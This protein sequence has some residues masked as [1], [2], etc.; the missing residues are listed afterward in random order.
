M[1]EKN[2]IYFIKYLAQLIP[3]RLRYRFIHSLYNPSS[4]SNKGVDLIMDNLYD[5]TLKMSISTKEFIGWNLFFFG[6]YESDV[7]GVLRKY[8]KNGDI[9]V[10]AG[11]NN[12]S[13]TILLSYLVGSNGQ[14]FAFEPIPKICEIL[15]KNIELN[16]FQDRVEIEEIALGKNIDARTGFYLMPDDAP[17][18]GMS[19]KYKFAEAGNKIIVNETTLDSFAEKKGINKIDFIKMDIQGSELDLILGAEKTIKKFKP[20]ILLEIDRNSI[21]NTNYSV[22]EIWNILTDLGYIIKSVTQDEG[23]INDIELLNSANWLALPR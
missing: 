14:V 2:K 7:N 12:G 1:T 5:A 11:A 8:I 16:N 20:V 6:F 13:E 15:R 21:K 4:N 17:N 3:K 22:K 19:S 18:Q 9:V 10:E 23:I